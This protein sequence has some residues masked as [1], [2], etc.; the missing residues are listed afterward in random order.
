MGRIR[1]CD[2]GGGVAL[3]EVCHWGWVI[4]F[5]KP[6]PFRNFEISALCLWIKYKLSASGQAWWRTPLI[7]VLRRQKQADF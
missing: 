3:E 7:P 1:R 5:Q 4:R 6:R 2:L